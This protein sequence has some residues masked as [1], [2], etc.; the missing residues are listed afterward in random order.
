MGVQA[1]CMILLYISLF[2]KLEEQ[3]Y[4]ITRARVQV[5]DTVDFERV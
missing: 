4:F 5:N 2:I 3:P 1:L